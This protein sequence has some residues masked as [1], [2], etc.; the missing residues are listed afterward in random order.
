M[1]T[2]MATAVVAKQPTSSAIKR[3]IQAD[4]SQPAA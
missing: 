4:A 1:T 3:R 2:V